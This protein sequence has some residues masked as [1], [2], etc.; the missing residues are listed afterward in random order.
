MRCVIPVYFFFFHSCGCSTRLCRSTRGWCALF[1]IIIT[2]IITYFISLYLLKF[3]SRSRFQSLGALVF[4][5]CERFV[6][7][8]F[9]C[10]FLRFCLSFLYHW[11]ACI[12]LWL[13]SWSKMKKAAHCLW[14][15]PTQRPRPTIYC[16]EAAHTILLLLLLLGTLCVY[17]G[18]VDF[19]KYRLQRLSPSPTPMK[20]VES[21]TQCNVQCNE[22]SSVSMSFAYDFSSS[23]TVNILIGF[24]NSRKKKKMKISFFPSE[25]NTNESEWKREEKNEYESN[26]KRWITFDLIRN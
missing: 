7:F 6:S 17:D 14:F 19:V 13:I 21:R 26:K 8:L 20:C 25:D 23:P 9:R 24:T 11:F 3:H 1:F 16:S 15:G 2:R 22:K 5:V 10:G 4:V 18:L 12:R